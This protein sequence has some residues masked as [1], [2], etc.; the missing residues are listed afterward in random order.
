MTCMKSRVSKR[1]NSS[2]LET[3]PYTPSDVVLLRVG[4][5]EEGRRGR[6]VTE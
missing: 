1:L 4:G 6:V 5:G 3:D 2:R